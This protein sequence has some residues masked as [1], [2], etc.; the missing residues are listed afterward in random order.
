MAFLSRL[1]RSVAL[2]APLIIVGTLAVG[3]PTA[4][5]DPCSG[6]SITI[7]TANELVEFSNCMTY[8][9]VGTVTL[10]NNI[11]LADETS[12]DDFRPIGSADPFVGTFDG[13]DK[14]ISGLNVGAAGS[15]SVGLFGFAGTT[16]ADATIKNV[17]LAA[18]QVT[19]RL[20]IG[21]LVGRMR[22]GTITN[23]RITGAVISGHESVALLA[24]VVEA[25]RPV[26]IR[27][28]RA[29]GTVTATGTAVAGIVGQVSLDV[30]AAPL[31]I[32]RVSAVGSSSSDGRAGGVV[33]QLSYAAS[34]TAL[35]LTDVAVRFSQGGTGTGF[36][37]V[38]G[39]IFDS[40][41]PHSGKALNLTR[42]YATGAVAP[43]GGIRGGILGFMDSTAAVSGVDGTVLWD[44]ETT[45]VAAG[46][47]AGYVDPGPNVAAITAVAA[48]RTT[49]Q[50]TSLA[51]FTASPAWPIV[52]AWASAGSTAAQPWGICASVG[53]GYPLLRTNGDTT[54]CLVPSAPTIGTPTQ[55]GRTSLTVPFTA[56]AA[57]DAPITGYEY[58]LDDGVN[59]LVP[60]TPTTTSPLLVTGLTA[61]TSYQVK[62]R[63]INPFGESLASGAAVATAATCAGDNSQVLE[64]SGTAADPYLIES[65][66][67]LAAIG[68]GTCALDAHH[69]QTADI[70]LPSVTSTPGALEENFTPIGSA[71][72]RF[73][74]VYDGGGH[75][76]DGLV[77]D[78]RRATPADDVGLFGVVGTGAEIS[79]VHLRDVRL[80]A[81]DDV[82]GL[83]GQVDAGGGS[84][85]VEDV[86]VTGQV[87]GEGKVGGLIGWG[88]S[89]GATG[90][91]T[92][93]RAEAD[94]DVALAGNSA[95]NAGG[96][97]GLLNPQEQ[98]NATVHAVGALGDVTATGTT[99]FAVGGLIGGIQIRHLSGT[100]ST[101]D[102][103]ITDVVA[104]GAVFVP[105]GGRA[106]GLVGAFETAAPSRALVID[107]AVA[108]GSVSSIGTSGGLIGRA[109]LNGAATAFTLT[110][111]YASGNVLEVNG[112]GSPSFGGL[113]GE[114]ATTSPA[115]TFRTDFTYARGAVPGLGK[116][117]VGVWGAPTLV[118]PSFAPTAYWDADTTE[119]S[120]SGIGIIYDGGKSTAQMTSIATYEA[121]NA[122][123]PLVP[124]WQAP[125]ADRTWG[126]CRSVNGGY[127]FLL[128]EYDAM[129][130]AAPAAPTALVATPG[131]GTAQIA[132]T[133]G[134]AGDSAITGYEVSIDGGAWTTAAGTATPVAVTG[135]ANGRRYAIRLRALSAVGAGAVSAAVDVAP[136]APSTPVTLR[137][138]KATVLPGGR[139][140][141]RI[142][143]AGPGRITVSGT[144][145]VAG[146][147]KAK[148]LCAA[149]KTVKKA[150]T[151][152]LV[153]ALD[154]KSRAALK[155]APLR[156]QLRVV[157]TPTSGKA[158]ATTETVTLPR[159]KR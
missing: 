35:T 132:F 34:N 31:T 109:M 133:A 85:L 136:A 82:G 88:Q 47:A 134:A 81:G 64:E 54:A 111:A 25:K 49:A 114:L 146:R 130:C 56:G 97:I 59:W 45:G 72:D 2:L 52:T 156:L 157:F 98:G 65:A 15:D 100:A 148:S 23:V 1:R 71:V 5:A 67:D 16:I 22:A 51:T 149:T 105:Y 145:A 53:G 42:V 80:G 139:V 36:G 13:N 7:S 76:I 60:D 12:P 91:F 69:L 9:G 117:I 14:T 147:A 58:S 10:G 123:W 26:V 84:V 40:S 95:S 140:Q 99:S 116:G 141:A 66:L 8:T 126:I 18:P 90:S 87:S 79:A 106:G 115:S 20:F 19:G 122:A 4:E 131:D 63:A 118:L 17:R 77:Y 143:V 104:R 96:A 107:G 86:T 125:A 112:T 101:T 94:V 89:S 32:E 128:M 33:G 37:G 138:A 73:T 21:G 153:C 70:S 78:D 119:S 102:V 28:S 24:G 30:A 144:R 129:P 75:R 158:T 43:S 3:A 74:G 27:D 38:V 135:L 11:N 127:P 152:T 48:G 92:L 44:T 113:I 50:M 6:A 120:V 57:G 124:L 159:A 121:P 93:R 155:R 61:G 41:G 55:T 103:E 154:K 68:T 29:Q 62:V 150:G 151:Y 39:M 46:A 110:N 83:V 142:Q 137:I 108:S